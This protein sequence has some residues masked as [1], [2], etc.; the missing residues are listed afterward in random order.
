MRRRIMPFV[1]AFCA[2]LVLAGCGGDAEG[3]SSPEP[4]NEENGEDPQAGTEPGECDEPDVVRLAVPAPSL[5]FVPYYLGRDT[6]IFEDHC[7]DLEIENLS[8]DVAVAALVSDEIDFTAAG[9]TAMR[10]AYEGAPLRA[11]M[12]TVAE[13]TTSL[14]VDPSIQSPADIEGADIGVLGTGDSLAIA[15][16]EWLASEGLDI[17]RDVNLLTLNATPDAFSSLVGGGVDA[18]M[19]TPPFDAQAEAEGFDVLI[20]VSEFFAGSQ[21]Q[22]ATTTSKIESDPELI[23]RFIQASLESIEL[24]VSNPTEAEEFVVDFLDMEQDIAA[25][26]LDV[27]MPALALDGRASTEAL[28]SQLPEGATE[29]ELEGTIDFSML[30]RVLAEREAG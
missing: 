30:D 3:S 1:P 2:A 27:F 10:A 16:G 25:R 12:I 13:S 19:L 21:G 7:I 29:E 14:I 23:E 9:G 22:V 8:G 4:S 11:V 24:M 15:L 5:N 17:Q 6:G 28:L 18:A 20:R 26:S